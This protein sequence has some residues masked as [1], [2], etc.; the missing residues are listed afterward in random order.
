[1]NKT[2]LGIILLVAFLLACIVTCPKKDAHTEAI[3]NEVTEAFEN[4]NKTEAK[5]GTA[6]GDIF[7]N[8]IAT[9][10]AMFVSKIAE[11]A[12]E[13]TLHINNYLVVSTGEMTYNGEKNIVSIGLLGHVF[14]TFDGEDLMENLNK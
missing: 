6:E 1:M 13:S 9:L 5:E 11:T 3:M 2:F 14:T 4:E 10:G 12:I 8:G 7:S